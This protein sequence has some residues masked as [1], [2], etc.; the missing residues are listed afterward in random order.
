MARIQSIEEQALEFAK[1]RQEWKNNPI[2]FFNEVL[3]IK[4]P[5]HQ[6]R[7]LL[8]CLK[9]NRIAICTGN[10]IGKSFIIGALAFFWF[11][12][13][14]S[15]EP[16]DSTVCII[17][18]VIFSQVKR[19][20]MA[21][22]KH[23]A[24]RADAYVKRRFGEEYTFLSK[25]FS[26][27]P[28]TVEY[29]YNELSYIMGIS[30]DNSNA[31]SGIHATRLMIIFDEAQ[32]IPESTY[33]GF[34]GVLQSGTSKQILLG[35]P[36]LPNGPT[37]EFYNAMQSESEFH[38]IFI[39]A[40]ETP[41][42]I[43]TGITLDSMLLP[44]SDP[45]SWRNK[46]DKYCG[47]NYK[48]AVKNDEIGLWEDT[49]IKKMPF[50]NLVN[51]ISAFNVLKS[52]GMNP[53]QYD[54]LTRIRALFPSGEGNCV[55]NQQ[56][57]ED[58]MDDYSN[59]EKHESGIRSMGVDISGG[60]GR[61]FSTIAVRDGNK[62]I[63]LDEYQLNAPDLEDKII[64]LYNEYGCEYCCVERD[65]IGKPIYDHLEYRDVINIIPIN[66]GGSAGF[67]DPL[68]YEE[69]T[70]TKEAKELYNRKRDELWFNL[71]NLLNPYTNQYPVLVPKNYKLKRHLMCATWKKGGTSNK[72][73][74]SPKDEMR[75]K[76]KESPD[77]A[78]AIIFA[79]ANIGE[80]GGLMSS[81]CG[82][83]TFNNTSW[84]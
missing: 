42:F 18:S 13:N 50:T 71:R 49:V 8:D 34:R 81:D 7:M 15:D 12:T 72:I 40:F 31:I 19:S 43:E 21:N 80:A 55:I 23:F 37:G 29:W 61:D 73:Q 9:H 75:K 6:K 59:P 57:L 84:S 22:L 41:N 1:Q 68:S 66:S 2:E 52:C 62:V 65:G 26:E 28:N 35:N 46:L 70:L 27:S 36:T 60:L 3:G 58:S 5:L 64:E 4:L 54:F 38:S 63:F 24:K 16:D 11:F 45:E 83:L 32:G 44:D 69:E 82:F 67:E 39:S 76:I 51:P 20:I 74:V 79:F 17:T 53:D 48:E 10:S 78:D 25:E 47:T 33:S 77:L 14:V 56:W 30:T